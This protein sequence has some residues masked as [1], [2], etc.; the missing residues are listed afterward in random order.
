M[1]MPKPTDAHKK[2]EMLLGTWEGEEKMNPSPW[3]P[4]GGMAQGKVVNRP[5]LDGFNVV[6]EYEQKAQ[7]KTTF[8][9]HGVFEWNP[10]ESCYIMYWWDSYGSPGSLHKGNFDG[11]VLTLNSKGEMG[12][13][14]A[15]F[16]L[17]ETG[18]YGFKMD[19]SQDGKTWATFM[20]GKY[21]K[22]G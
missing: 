15:I 6:Q 16:D 21:S 18:A 9:G 14:R 11:K 12:M 20:E 10:K 1:D 19:M 2:L 13:S 5:A 7:G 22:K 8:T 3:A 17:R 4:E